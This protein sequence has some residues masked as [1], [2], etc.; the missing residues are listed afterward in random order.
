MTVTG[1]LP[2]LQCDQDQLVC[3]LENIT[4]QCVGTGMELTISW[5]LDS[6]LIA[7][8]SPEGESLF[9]NASYP[10]TAKML[11]NGLSSNISFLAE[12]KSDPVTLEC[13]S[14]GETIASNTWSYSIFGLSLNFCIIEVSNNCTFSL[15]HRATRPTNHRRGYGSEQL[16]CQ[17]CLDAASLQ[18]FLHLHLGNC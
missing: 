8:F 13:L 7:Q 3:P 9:S 10:A 4:C 18:L 11:E 15:Q 16:L 17:H 14:V 6:K 12:L 2:E 5:I 1:V